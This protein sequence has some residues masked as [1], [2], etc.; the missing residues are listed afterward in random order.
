MCIL[1]YK[2]IPL[3]IRDLEDA[4]ILV[5]ETLNTSCI[6]KAKPAS[7]V[8]WIYNM[9][10]EPN[11]EVIDISS[12]EQSDGPYT[13][14]ISTI[15]WKTSDETQRKTVSGYYTCDAENAVGMTSHTL[16]LDIQCK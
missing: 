3:A 12:F 15:T 7:I 6:Y 2:A 9:T 10:E 11:T 5:N 8:T 4:T 16:K 13:V 1:F 14:T